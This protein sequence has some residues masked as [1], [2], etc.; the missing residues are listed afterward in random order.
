MDLKEYRIKNKS[1]VRHPWEVARADII[2]K[3]MLKYCSKKE[4]SIL[5]I[6]TGDAFSLEQ[7][8]Y[9]FKQYRSFGLDIALS[10]SEIKSINENFLNKKCNITVTNN[11]KIIREFSKNHKFD[12]ICLMDVIEHIENDKNFL[13]QTIENYAIDDNT[14]VVITV[15]AF[16]KVFLNHDRF[17]GHYRRYNKESLSRVLIQNNLQI[18]DIGYFF[19]SLLIVRFFTCLAEKIFHINKEFKSTGNWSYGK[20]LS[21]LISKCLM[22]DFYCSVIIKKIGIEL[23]GL[24]VYAIARGCKNE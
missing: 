11:D 7:I 21:N 15:P 24:S 19:F 9:L 8:S 4:A 3:L 14:L 13:A 23:P 1:F 16:Q 10:D 2:K 20:F 18:L 12:I 6:G 17:L 22:L 5:D